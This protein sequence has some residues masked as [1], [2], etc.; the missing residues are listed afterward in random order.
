M[1]KTVLQSLERQPVNIAGD[2]FSYLS[3]FSAH[4][5]EIWGEKFAT[6]E[7][8]YQCAKLKPSLERESIKNSKSPLQAWLLAQE[9][10]KNPDIQENLPR[11]ELL[12]LVEELF[13]AKYNQHE[14]IRE[15]LEMTKGRGIL[16]VFGTDNFWGTGEDGK[17][18][19]WMG[20]IWIKIRDENTR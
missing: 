11:K 1:L 16:K 3:P 18:E 5:I 12:N 14:E 7:H 15:I 17:G 8:A 4:Q 19:N 2:L 20:R 10:K 6:I 13:R 9:Y